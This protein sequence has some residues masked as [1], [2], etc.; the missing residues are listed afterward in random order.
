MSE[1][2]QDWVL[3]ETGRHL[4]LKRIR[5][6]SDV[7]DIPQTDREARLVAR[8]VQIASGAGVRADRV[9]IVSFYVALKSQP[10]S[11]LVGPANTG[12][13]ALVQAMAGTLAHGDSLR[14]Q[15]MD[16]HAWWAAGSG[17]VALFTEAQ[18][19]FNVAKILSLIEEARQPGNARRPHFACMLRVSPAELR[20]LFVPLAAQLRRS[21]LVYLPFS[22]L[23]EPVF[24]PENVRLIGTLDSTAFDSR[25]LGLGSSVV[26]V[27][28]SESDLSHPPRSSSLDLALKVDFEFPEVCLRDQRSACQKLRQIIGRGMQ[29]LGPLFQVDA[30][31]R[32]FGVQV[33]RWEYGQAMLHLANAWSG[34]GIG[35]FEPGSD[36][37]AEVALD[38]VIERILVAHAGDIWQRPGGLRQDLKNVLDGRFARA[39]GALR[40]ID[41]WVRPE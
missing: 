16:G 25:R 24:F 2:R 9:S 40:F 12:K 32:R 13:V 28:P 39:T 20:G 6:A 15:T 1:H 8:L 36:Q 22:E 11:I 34:G 27:H 14:C 26:F 38:V 7:D 17:S 29:P 41:Q 21:R 37:N 30:T 19:R 35:L 33:P 31:L 23:A 4:G 3:S 5:L 18:W 10:L